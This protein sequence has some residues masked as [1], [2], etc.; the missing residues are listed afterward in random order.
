MGEVIDAI[1]RKREDDPGE[2]R[3]PPC[4]R[5]PADQQRDAD[6][7]EDEAREKHQVVDENRRDPEPMQRRDDEARHISASE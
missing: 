5:E 2:H 4:G 6:T 7:R 3:R 1:R